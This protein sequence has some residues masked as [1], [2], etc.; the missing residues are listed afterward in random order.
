LFWKS[1]CSPC[2]PVMIWTVI[3]RCLD[4]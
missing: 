1:H 3:R 2:H 4:K